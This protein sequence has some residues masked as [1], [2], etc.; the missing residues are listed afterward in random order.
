AVIAAAIIL[1]AVALF[2]LS[3]NLIFIVIMLC[4][5]KTR[6]LRR[7]KANDNNIAMMLMMSMAISDI[8][9]SVS[10][11]P[12]SIVEVIENG[13]WNLG[14]TL[15]AARQTVNDFL[16]SVSIF[17]V[18]FMALDRY[19]A[20]CKPL[21]YRLLT[22]KTGYVM[23]M[24]SWLVPTFLV[25]LPRLIGWNNLGA[26]ESVG[27]TGEVCESI[28]KLPI[29]IIIVTLAIYL[30]FSTSY[31]F[32][33]FILREVSHVTTLDTNQVALSTSETP[34]SSN[35]AMT[36]RSNMATKAYRT[37]GCLV[38][39]FTVCWFPS[40]IF[41][42]LYLQFERTIPQWVVLMIS[43]LAYSNGAI[44]PILYLGNRSVR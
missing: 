14:E 25:V 16:C 19:M 10:V 6:N 42:T 41:V 5:N 29:F 21:S 13:K 40:W 27:C 1:S 9:F 32:Y 30:P 17:H 23:V 22:N 35:P 31:V 7:H 33:F 24:V 4:T 44:N 2:T 43:W 11:M 28:Y 15:C 8:T 20:V 34:G 36:S 18:N 37:V 12:L 39:C 38:F 3:S 26:K